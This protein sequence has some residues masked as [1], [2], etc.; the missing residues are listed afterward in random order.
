VISSLH[1][2]LLASVSL[3]GFFDVRDRRIPNWITLPGITIALLLN[4]FE[5]SVPLL[6]S[7]LGFLLAAGLMFLAFVF[8]WL[9]AGDVK[10]FALVG[11]IVGLPSVPRVFFY[12][13][14]V[15]GL[16]AG[17]VFVGRGTSLNAI[18]RCWTD[19]KLVVCTFGSIMPQPIAERTAANDSI[20]FGVAIGIGTLVALYLDPNG[21]WAGF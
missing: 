15:S 5:G 14:L 4:A 13:S 6:Q 11:A 21:K 7:F 20:P 16:L 8:G 3:A 2:L 19:I 9:G 17:W 12:T 1:I 18:S 10:L